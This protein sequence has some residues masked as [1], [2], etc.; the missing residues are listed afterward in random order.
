MASKKVQSLKNSILE[1]YKLHHDKG[2]NYTYNEWKNCELSKSRE[3][4]IRRI[5]KKQQE[6]NHDIVIKMFENLKAKVHV[7]NQNGLSSLLKF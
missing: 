1:F 6:I 5:K 3:S 7:A 2:I 4:M